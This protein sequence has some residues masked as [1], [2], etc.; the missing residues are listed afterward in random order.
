[1]SLE[2]YNNGIIEKIRNI[3]NEIRNLKYD[4]KL[5]HLEHHVNSILD[6]LGELILQNSIPEM[7]RKYDS[8]WNKLDYI[9]ENEVRNTKSAFMKTT[10][11]NAPYIRT[12]EYAK[13]LK[14]AISLI[15][16][17]L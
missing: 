15:E 13:S 11:K 6:Y 2:K 3:E 12:T 16:I 9:K 4:D 5:F 14:N 8:I 17:E 7:K 1:M 10:K